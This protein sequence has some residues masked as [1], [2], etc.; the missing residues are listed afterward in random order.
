MQY[1]V[2]TYSPKSEINP[3]SFFVLSKGINS[4]KPLATPIPN[5]FQVNCQD[6]ETRNHLFWLCKGLWQ[7]NEFRPCLVGSVIEF[8]RIGDFKKV[9]NVAVENS[10][11]NFHRFKKTSRNLDKLVELENNYLRNLQ[12]IQDAKRALYINIIRHKN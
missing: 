12:L 7:T 9:L 6:N 11:L 5:C 10:L 1:Q 2:K 8:I 3:S 4:G